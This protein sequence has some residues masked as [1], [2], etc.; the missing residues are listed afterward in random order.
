MDARLATVEGRADDA[1]ECRL[2][3]LAFG[4]SI[5]NGGGELQ[6]GVALQSWAL[7]VARG[8]GLPFSSYAFD[9][10]QVAD[11][12]RE[13]ISAFQRSAFKPAARYDVGCLYIGVNDVRRPHWDA[14]SFL[15][16]YR[17]ALEFISQRS[18]R[19]LAVTAPLAL[20]RPAAGPKVHELNSGVERVAH[21]CGALVVDLSSFGA[22]NHVMAD[23]VHPTAFGQVA[24][25]ERAL[26]ALER[27]GLPAR[28]PPSALVRFQTTRWG[29]LR[30]DCTYGYRS[31]KLLAGTTAK[32]ALSTTEVAAALRPSAKAS[33]LSD[34]R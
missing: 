6:Y 23:R 18:D 13:Q 27:D 1:R 20:G 31:A 9:G 12:V 32:R 24:I 34:R 21:E 28:V 22:R 19:T 10:A 8:L 2:G 4:D 5:T 17:R 7:W 25:A 26:A 15:A 33:P 29:R 30:A 3:V 16:Q 11:V 14:P